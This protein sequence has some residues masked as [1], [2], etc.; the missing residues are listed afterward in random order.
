MV[1]GNGCFEAFNRCQRTGTTM[2]LDKLFGNKVFRDLHGVGGSPFPQIV[3]DHPHVQG[4]SLGLVPAYTPY[5]NLVF[6]VRVDGHGIGIG[7]WII[8]YRYPGHIVQELA[9]I[10]KVKILVEFYV[11]GFRMPACR[12][13]TYGRGT[14]AKSTV[15]QYFLGFTCQFHFFLGIAVLQKTSQWGS[16]FLPMG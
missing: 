2:A 4:I 10:L 5:E 14:N 1:K 6:F 13:N 3:R 15:I 8:L 9:D 11:Y 12:G 16:A 7:V